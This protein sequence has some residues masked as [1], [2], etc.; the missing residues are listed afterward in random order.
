MI[1][2]RSI[3]RKI[4]IAVV[5]LFIVTPGFAESGDIG[6]YGMWAT[7]GNRNLVTHTIIDELNRFGPTATDVDNA[8][9]PIEARL[10]LAFMGGMAKVGVALDSSLVRFAII[11]MLLAYAFWVAFEAYNLI[12]TGEDAKKIVYDILIKGMIIS[13]WLIILLNLGIVKTFTLIMMPIIS[14]GTYIATTIWEGITSVVGY[15][16]PNTCEAIKQY[17]VTN[18]S[19]VLTT[20]DPNIDANTLTG[21]KMTSESAAE[22]LCITTQM[23]AFFVTIIKVGWGWVVS[24][25]GVSLFTSLFGLYITYLALKSI[26]K[27][28]FMTLGVIADLFLSLL[29]LPFTAIAETT[30]KT[31]YKGVAG[32]IFNSFLGIFKAESLET[33]INRFIKAALYFICLAIAIGVSVALLTFVIDPAT[34]RIS[35]DLNGFDGAILLVLT[36]LLVCYMADKAKNLAEDWGGKIDSGLGDKIQKDAQDLWKSTKEN[37]KKFYKLVKKD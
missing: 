11:F 5:A 8:F 34:G 28:L 20:T 23:S 4:L 26:W 17:A 35:S 25:V 7:D 29:M 22:L 19:P 36:L 15:S 12:G 13:A 24:G 14:F 30:A 32:D 1:T 33:Q 21:L 16:L 2:I 37:W 10:G 6:D 18:I 3:L 9:V 31:N 27:Y